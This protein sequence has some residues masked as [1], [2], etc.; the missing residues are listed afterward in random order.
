MGLIRAALTRSLQVL[1]HIDFIKG[2]FC[3]PCGSYE[4]MNPNLVQKHAKK[5]KF[6]GKSRTGSTGKGDMQSLTGGGRQN[7]ESP[8]PGVLCLAESP[9]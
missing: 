1:L 7:L 2:K 3:C 5:H 6:H 9:T 8:G 4:N